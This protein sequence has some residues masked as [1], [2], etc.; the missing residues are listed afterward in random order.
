MSFGPLSKKSRVREVLRRLMRKG[1]ERRSLTRRDLAELFQSPYPPSEEKEK[2]LRKFEMERDNPKLGD[3]PPG[4]RDGKI[5]AVDLLLKTS[6]EHREAKRAA[7]LGMVPLMPKSVADPEYL[8][9]ETCDTF[10]RSLLHGNGVRRSKRIRKNIK[11][12]VHDFAEAMESF[13]K[14]SA[15]LTDLGFSRL[16]VDTQKVGIDLFVLFEQLDTLRDIASNLEEDLGNPLG[17]W[18][19]P[20]T[21]AA[22]DAGQYLMDHGIKRQPA[23]KIV[24]VLMQNQPRVEPKSW[25]AI[26]HAMD[27]AGI[28]RRPKKSAKGGQKGYIF[29]TPG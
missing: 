1:S 24:E 15:G 25:R 14:A 27:K 6:E 21:V 10:Y 11:G 26:E 20:G 7:C 17:R 13:S 22:V 2:G 23:A 9:S 28:S 3:R 19:D 8:A 4:E 16:W 5:C 18:K 12:E 29:L